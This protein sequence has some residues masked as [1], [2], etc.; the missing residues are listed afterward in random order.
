M[1]SRDLMRT[2]LEAAET[3]PAPQSVKSKET[4]IVVYARIGNMEGLEQ[5]VRWE[6]HHQIEARFVNGNTCRVRKVTSE[7]KDSYVY[8]FKVKEKSEDGGKLVESV[9]E[10]TVDVDKAFFDNFKKIAERELVKRRYTFSSKMVQLDTKADDG[11]PTVVEIPNIQY[12]VDVYTK[13][14]GERSE[15]CKI[16]I[17]VDSV[18]D[19]INANHKNVGDFKVNVKVSH[20]PFQPTDLLLA[21][22]DDPTVRGR[23]KE[24]WEELARPLNEAKTG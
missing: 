2:A 15:Y 4:E 17:E 14:D 10:Q 24:I 9:T 21:H 1:R 6:D 18:L 12:E 3:T 20:L 13:A 8:T 11:G 23:I 16:D 19:F 5:C 7:G 22:T